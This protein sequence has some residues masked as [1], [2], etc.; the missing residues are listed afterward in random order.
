MSPAESVMIPIW[1]AVVAAF[2][3]AG[4]FV[5]GVMGVVSFFRAWERGEPEF[6]SSMPALGSDRS[7]LHSMEARLARG[8]LS[9]A[10]LRQMRDALDDMLRRREAAR[11]NLGGG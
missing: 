3:L 7:P 9:E 10:E 2:A 4:L 6:S 11:R 1:I 8:D 5:L